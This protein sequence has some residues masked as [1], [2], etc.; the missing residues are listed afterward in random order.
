MCFVAGACARSASW[1]HCRQ[2]IWRRGSVSRAC[3]A[4]AGARRG[5][6]AARAVGARGTLRAGARSRVAD[7]RA[8]AAVVRARPTDGAAVGASRAARSRRGGAARAAASGQSTPRRARC[9][10]V[11]AAA[12]ADA[13]C[14]HAAHAGAARSRV[15]SAAGR[16]S[17]AS[18]WPSIRRPA[19]SS[20]ISLLTRPLPSPEQVSTLMAR[21]QALMG[22]DALRLAGAGR[23]VAAGGVRDEAVRA[24]RCRTSE[25]RPSRGTICVPLRGVSPFASRCAASAFPVAGARA[26]GRGARPRASTIDRRG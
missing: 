4:A 2:T 17:I 15:A 7:R 12:G 6:A 8:R 11:A 22:E 3:L 16:R 5:S 13:R 14:A 23:F 20:S 1:R 26:C 9:T 18:S 10:S 19:A 25:S 24:Q 21:L